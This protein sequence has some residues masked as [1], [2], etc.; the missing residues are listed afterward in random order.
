VN[1]V[2]REITSRN[3]LVLFLTIAAPSVALAAAAPQGYFVDS[4][5]AFARRPASVEKTDGDFTMSIHRDCKDS[6][7]TRLLGIAEATYPPREVLVD[8]AIEYALEMGSDSAHVPLW[9]CDGVGVER[10][11]YAVTLSAVEYYARLTENFRRHIFW[12]VGGTPLRWT[13]FTYRATITRKANVTVGPES[14]ASVYV[15]DMLLDWRY[16]DGIFTPVT[17]AHRIVVLTPAGK[18]LRVEG[19]GGADE[20]VSMSNHRRVGRDRRTR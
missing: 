15:A 16:D 6:I 3:V 13:D 1:S 2:I 14:F 5:Q 12:G 17:R 19:D 18:V 9:W 10:I 11:P 20:D 7:G 8:F 4:K